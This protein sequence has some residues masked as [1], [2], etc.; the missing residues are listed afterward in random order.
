MR[1]SRI[2]ES[3]GDAFINSSVAAFG[4]W[5]T[6]MIYVLPF[7]YYV[8]TKVVLRRIHSSVIS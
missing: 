4:R 5:I 2:L 1:V 7:M 8:V 6:I 3:V